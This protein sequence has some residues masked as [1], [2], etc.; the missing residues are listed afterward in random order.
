LARPASG[1]CDRA[2]SR[3]I[4]D[5][6]PAHGPVLLATARLIT[7]DLDE[8]QDLV[9]TTF[10]LAIRN[11]GGLRDPSALRAWLL[12]IEVREAFR[13]VRRL[14]RLVSLDGRV[15][16]LASPSSDL[17]Q[18]ADVRAGLAK[19]LHRIR[20]AIAFHHLAGLSVAETASAMGLSEN[21]VRR[22]RPSA[23]RARTTSTNRS[24]HAARRPLVEPDAGRDPDARS[25]GCGGALRWPRRSPSPPVRVAGSLPAHAILGG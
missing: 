10:E 19:L 21:A 4:V 9:Q 3:E 17:A 1:P 15:V 13:L 5:E 16:E 23:T 18:R 7:L 20:A 25:H 14:R 8:A 22:Q 12:R 11:I 6:L 24:R 2:H